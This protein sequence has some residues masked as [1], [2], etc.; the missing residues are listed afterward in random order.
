MVG[1]IVVGTLSGF[2]GGRFD[3]WTMSVVDIFLAFPPLLL[4]VAVVAIFSAGLVPV[5][6]AIALADLPRLIRLQRSQVL[7]LKS[8]PFIDAARMASAPTHWIMLKHITP[9]SLAPMFVAA[10]ITAAAAI[11]TEA[12]LSF[13]GLG[14]T[15]PEPSL[16]NLIREGQ[17]FLQDA[18]WIST[19]PGMIIFLIAISLHFLSDGIREVM[20]PRKNR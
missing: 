1:G 3:C 4:A 7:S 8:R 2:F 18:W 20:D 12:T 6:L 15:P 10:S 17:M 5:I 11:L 13:L 9:N 14:I 16:G 19:M